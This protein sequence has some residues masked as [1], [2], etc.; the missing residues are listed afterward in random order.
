SASSRTVR[1]PRSCLVALSQRGGNRVDD[2]QRIVE[3]RGRE[4]QHEPIL[5]RGRVVL[6][7]VGLKA[8]CAH[9]P[10]AAV[11]A[12]LELDSDAELRPPAIKAPATG[13]RE[14]TLRN[15]IRQ[16]SRLEEPPQL[17]EPC[18][19]RARRRPRHTWP[20]AAAR[21]QPGCGTHRLT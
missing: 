4:A 20:A 21:H 17:I 1:P 13:R 3:M 12:A 16:A 10:A 5:E 2:A 14:C 9:M 18:L 11:E 8:G 15:R 19:E 6:L 7:A